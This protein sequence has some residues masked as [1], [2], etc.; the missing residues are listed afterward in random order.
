MLQK[1]YLLYADCMESCSVKRFGLETSLLDAQM[2]GKTGWP[3]K[4]PH[5]SK[6]ILRVKGRKEN[7]KSVQ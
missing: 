7:H 2:V 5:L 1:S 6:G 3:A 4:A